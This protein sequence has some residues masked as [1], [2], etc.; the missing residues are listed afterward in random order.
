MGRIF[1]EKV[2]FCNFERHCRETPLCDLKTSPRTTQDRPKTPPRRSYRGTFFMLN[3][4]FDFGTFLGPILV[5][6]SPLLA[7]P[8]WLFFQMSPQE[9]P[10]RPQEDPKS[11]RRDFQEPRK[12][13]HRASKMPLRGYR[14]TCKTHPYPIHHASKPPSLEAPRPVIM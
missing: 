12:N 1:C 10:K 8:F 7:G 6:K 13:L 11:L 3:F 5:P 2:F 9:L 14:L 4:V